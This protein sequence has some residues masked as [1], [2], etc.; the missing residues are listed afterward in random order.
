M[1]TLNSLACSNLEN[2]NLLSLIVPGKLPQLVLLPKTPQ[3]KLLTRSL[4]SK[5]QETNVI[6]V[7]LCNYINSVAQ[8]TGY[9]VGVSQLTSPIFLE[10]KTWIDDYKN[11]ITFIK[12]QANIWKDSILPNMVSIPRTIVNYNGVFLQHRNRIVALLKSLLDKED[13]VVRNEIAEKVGILLQNI[14][15]QKELVNSTAEYLQ[16]FQTNLSTSK[17]EIK[18]M[19]AHIT[20]EDTEISAGIKKLNDDIA[21]LQSECAEHNRWLTV[22]GVSIGISIAVG[23]VAITLALSPDPLSK[24]MLGIAILCGCVGVLGTI[25]GIVGTIIESE[26]VD[27]LTRSIRDKSLE[28]NKK[29]SDILTLATAQSAV[30]A[31]ES[32][33]VNAKTALANLQLVWENLYLQ[34]SELHQN[35]EDNENP[36]GE[37]RIQEALDELENSK[38]DWKQIVDAAR[39]MAKIEFVIENEIVIVEK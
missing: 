12:T 28:L 13:E 20:Q 18:K 4:K 22:S 32:S 10:A 17:A 3:V 33:C 38:S 39:I 1:F 6:E 36:T 34:L 29:N 11:N 15:E 26:N 5:S 35:L 27:R 19:L 31:L 7:L 23:G 30:E 16:E 25:G 8:V 24:V 14:S 9:C 37:E 2:E 21:D